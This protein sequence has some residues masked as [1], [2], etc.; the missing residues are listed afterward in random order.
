M[1]GMTA[2]YIGRGKYR[3]GNIRRGRTPFVGHTHGRQITPP[4]R[5]II[6]TLLP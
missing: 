2:L 5:L 1:I 3:V 4:D 6:I